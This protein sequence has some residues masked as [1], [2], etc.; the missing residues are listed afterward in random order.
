VELEKE[1]R[2]ILEM[3]KEGLSLNNFLRRRYLALYLKYLKSGKCPLRCQA[4][5]S[6][7]FL[8]PSGDLFPCAVYDKK[9]LNISRLNRSFQDLW[10]SEEA[11]ILSREC[12]GN[13]CPSCWSPCDAYSAIAGSLGKAIL[14]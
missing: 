6:T 3:D 13:L 9:L 2:S 10:N 8:D 12:S 4:L 1:I 14:N 5:S 7:C 11:K